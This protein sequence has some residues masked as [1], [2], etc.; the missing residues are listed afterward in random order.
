MKAPSVAS[1]SRR[2][3]DET[4][5]GFPGR[6]MIQIHVLEGAV[7]ASSHK[8]STR[9]RTYQCLDCRKLF[10]RKDVMNRHRQRTCSDGLR[11]T[12]ENQ[13]TDTNISC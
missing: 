7:N 1:R 8:R 10:T 2:K 9:E 11:R 3:S 5:G 13:G 6:G 4:T 12:E